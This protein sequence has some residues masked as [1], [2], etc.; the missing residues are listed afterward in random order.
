M[1]YQ[2]RLLE[3]ENR[4]GT[5]LNFLA[6]LG[7]NSSIP[8]SS[9]V[10]LV[11]KNQPTSA[12]NVKRLEFDPWVGKISWRRAWQ[13]IPLFLP[14]ESYGQRSLVGYIHGVVKSWTRLSNFHFGGVKTAKVCPVNIWGPKRE[15]GLELLW[16]T[17]CGVTKSQT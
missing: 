11:V 13:P 4:A 16:T 15:A 3:A 17:V 14:G 9:W 10:V 8:R 2:Y 7:C 1:F 12:G 6:H 5:P